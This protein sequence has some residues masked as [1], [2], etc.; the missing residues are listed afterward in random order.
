VERGGELRL[1]EGLHVREVEV[2]AW[3]SEAPRYCVIRARRRLQRVEGAESDG[4]NLGVEGSIEPR[5]DARQTTAAW[6]NPDEAQRRVASAKSTRRVAMRE[7]K[8]SG[9]V[10]R[11]KCLWQLSGAR[12]RFIARGR[13]G[14]QDLAPGIAQKRARQFF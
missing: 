14:S 1:R 6:R 5:A 12:D 9:R 13:N 3:A 7:E 11:I 10:A 2:A 8:R 4:A